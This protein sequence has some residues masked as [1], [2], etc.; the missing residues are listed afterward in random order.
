MNTTKEVQL[1][2]RESVY[3][4]LVILDA[5]ILPCICGKMHH[6]HVKMIFRFFTFERNQKLKSDAKRA[7]FGKPSKQR[8]L[9]KR[10]IGTF[11]KGTKMLFLPKKD[12]LSC[13]NLAVSIIFM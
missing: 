2:A 11:L 4:L 9:V 8:I 10:I 7:I 3:W 1:V 5:V 12:K 13:H 6:V